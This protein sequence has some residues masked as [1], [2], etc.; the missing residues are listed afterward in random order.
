METQTRLTFFARG[1]PAPKGS[2]KTIFNKKLGRN[3]TFQTNA[4]KQKEWADGVRA[5]YTMAN[6]N[7]E[8]GPKRISLRFLMPRPKYHYDSRGAIRPKYL[9]APH[10]VK[11]DMDKL[12]RT[13]FD[14]LD[15][16]CYDGDQ[17]V[18]RMGEVS[19]EYAFGNPGAVIVI[20]SV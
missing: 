7:M 12:I 9:N 3:M 15:G 20:E 6:G 8:D 13:V 5:A 19:K 18:C 14:A 1:V 17:K 16:L 4:P 2:A 11:P 10:T